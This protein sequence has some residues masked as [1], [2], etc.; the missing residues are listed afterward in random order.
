MSGW[1]YDGLS[2]W[3]DDDT[4]NVI[5]TMLHHIT[6]QIFFTLSDSIYLFY[7]ILIFVEGKPTYPEKVTILSTGETSETW[8]SVLGDYKS[9]PN[10]PVYPEKVTISS[11]GE[12]FEAFPSFLG[13]YKMTDMTKSARPVWRK[14]DRDDRYLFYDGN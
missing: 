7:L 8:P 12:L 9:I 13:V 3:L 11:I 1:Q 2:S 4:L 14:T 6:D 10:G 5:G